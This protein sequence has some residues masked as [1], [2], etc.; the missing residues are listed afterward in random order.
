MRVDGSNPSA[1]ITSYCLTHMK[2]G[3]V[4]KNENKRAEKLARDI[5]GFFGKKGSRVLDEDKLGEADYIIVLGGDGTLIHKACKLSHLG[6]PFVGINIGNLGFLT[7]AESTDWRSAADFVFD[8]KVVVSE[9]IM[10]EAQLR[11]HEQSFDGQAVGK[12]TVVS[13]KRFVS[14]YLAVN[15]FVIKGQFRVIDL[16]IRVGEQDLLKVHGDGVIIA[17]QSGS[18]AYSLSAG[19]PIVD[20]DLDCLLVTPINPI[21]LPVPSVVFSPAH[22]VNVKVVRGGDVYL[23]IDGQENF[24]LGPQDEIVVGQAKN[25]VKVGYFDKHYFVRLLNAKFG[26]AGRLRVD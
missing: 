25:K 14:R 22:K 19:G 2:I 11:S 9:R 15:E 23:V 24:A 7:A 16:D 20:P 6:I 10:L 12:K 13:S 8:G 17:S 3:V 26:L 21:G 18:T 5:S 1:P 4:F